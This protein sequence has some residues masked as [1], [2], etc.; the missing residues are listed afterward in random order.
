[1]E[2]FNLF[3]PSSLNEALE[4][5]SKEDARVISGGT[6]LVVLLRNRL[7][8]L[9]YLVS[10]RKIPDLAGIERCNGGVSIG[11]CT[12]LRTIENSPLVAERLPL[13]RTA[14]GHIGNVRVRAAAMAG[15][16]LCEAD[17]Q[18]DLSVALMALGGRVRARGCRGE[19]VIPIEDFYVGPYTT[20][21]EADELVTGV[22]VD[23]APKGAGVAYLKYVTGP[24]TDRPCVAVAAVIDLDSAGRCV[25]VRLVAGG[26]NG[27][28]SRPLRVKAAEDLVMG[29]KLT[30]EAI[31]EMSAIACGEADPVSDLKAPAWYKKQ[32][33]QVFCRRALEEALAQK[34]RSSI[35]GGSAI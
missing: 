7:L 22:E 27:V 30:A 34:S 33:V 9:R 20:A 32:M 25:Y 8:S 35:S 28:S 24:A 29:D 6:A 11:A 1:M 3:E 5:L 10:L 14:V 2:K 21:L 19:R 15:G 4:I 26:V 23:S 12:R 17:Y 18:S 31:A 16:T 13:L